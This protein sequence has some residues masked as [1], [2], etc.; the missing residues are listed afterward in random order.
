MAACVHVSGCVC[1]GMC[2][3]QV[4]TRACVVWCLYLH[5]DL[6]QVC[7]A[8][9]GGGHPEVGS[10]C[11]SAT[12]SCV[13]LGEVMAGVGGVG[14]G[15]GAHGSL[16]HSFPDRCLQVLSSLMGKGTMRKLRPKGKDKVTKAQVSST[17]IFLSHQLPLGKLS[18]F[19]PSGA[20]ACFPKDQIQLD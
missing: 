20:W 10:M 14:M 6:G 13:L 16:P 17:E 1:T 19:H 2:A 4:H 18:G 3:P 15:K 5:M 11:G 8:Q 7:K 12:E 9:Q